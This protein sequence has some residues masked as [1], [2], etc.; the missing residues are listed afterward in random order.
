MSKVYGYLRV[1][2]DEQ[3]VNNQRYGVVSFAASRGFEISDGDWIIDDGVSGVKDPDKRQLGKL[4][5]KCKPGDTIIC[6]EL[7]RLGRKMLMV[8]SILEH[9]MKNKIKILT[10]KDN[11]ELG[12]NVQSSI[13]AFAFSLASQLERDFIA[14]RT[15]E[16]LKVKKLKGILLGAPRAARPPK[17][18]FSEE[19]LRD[20]CD[21]YE[22]HYW[23][24]IK[25]LHN[26]GVKFALD[27]ETAKNILLDYGLYR[28]KAM[29]AAITFSDN[30]LE[31]ASFPEWAKFGLKTSILKDCIKNKT[32]LPLLGIQSVSLFFEF[33]PQ[34][35]F[36]STKP[37]SHHDL[38][39]RDL[40]FNLI[41]QMS[42]IPEIYEK[43]SG[44]NVSYDEVYDYISNDIELHTLYRTKAHQLLIKKNQRK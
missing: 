36:M 11:Y 43:L 1:S 18:R 24:D 28:G 2:S 29:G 3:D 13:L 32:G 7:S 15:A 34:K 42:T 16:A 22:A 33:T 25:I 40:V 26:T 17:R 38:I 31:S 6:S 19:L 14:Q 41:N 12:D 21:Y 35:D 27:P 8:M 4:L 5:D 30:R 9:C 44:L 10:V 23:Y 39:D 20:V 37:I